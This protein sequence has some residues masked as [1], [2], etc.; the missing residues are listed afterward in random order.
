M[1]TAFA[2]RGGASWEQDLSRGHWEALLR[3]GCL[4]NLS[5]LLRISPKPGVQEGC[6][7]GLQENHSPGL[8]CGHQAPLL[9]GGSQRCSAI[10]CHLPAGRSPAHSTAPLGL[11]GD[12]HRK[13]GMEFALS[14]FPGCH[15]RDLQKAELETPG[16][17]QGSL[18]PAVRPSR[19]QHPQK[20]L[21]P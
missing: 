13:G 21:A 8:L 20:C 6:F 19:V 11:P 4:R 18:Q 14:P 9:S 17:A 2:L 1:D 3:P 7:G 5:A 16:E 12:N 10:G 15:K